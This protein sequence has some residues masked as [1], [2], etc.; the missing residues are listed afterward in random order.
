MN[1]KPRLEDLEDRHRAWTVPPEQ[2]AWDE[3]LK[4]LTTDELR[5]LAEP[6]DEAASLVPCP[7]IKKMFCGCRSDERGRRGFEAHPDLG[8]EFIRRANTLLERTSEIM[9]REVWRRTEQ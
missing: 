7:H 6:S 3:L 5:W 1:L 9:G 2:E 4:R 8:D